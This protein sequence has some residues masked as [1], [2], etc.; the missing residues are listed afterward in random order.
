M[1]PDRHAQRARAAAALDEPA[2]AL[3]GDDQP[4]ELVDASAPAVDRDHLIAALEGAGGGEA[5]GH[6]GDR[7]AGVRPDQPPEEEEQDEAE[8]EVHGRAGEDHDD[9]LPDGLGVV[10]A[11]ANLLRELLGGVHAADLHVAAERDGADRIL[12][13][14]DLLAHEQRR[15]EQ[16]EALHPHAHR[17]GGG[18][19]PRLVEHDQHHEADERQEPAHARAPSTSSCACRRASASAS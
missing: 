8:R 1:A 11:V 4:V 18:E 5:L 16:R 9:S 19:V 7:V 13:L 2:G 17:L 14:A 15:E 6:R 10:G 3:V 12:G